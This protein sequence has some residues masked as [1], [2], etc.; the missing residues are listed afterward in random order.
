MN[1]EQRKMRYGGLGR[2]NV[3][4]CVVGGGWGQCS[5]RCRDEQLKGCVSP[6]NLRESLGLKNIKSSRKLV[7]QPLTK[8]QAFT[9]TRNKIKMSVLFPNF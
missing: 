3:E 9:K 7:L 5:P 2:G 4:I 8:A 6:Q 1:T